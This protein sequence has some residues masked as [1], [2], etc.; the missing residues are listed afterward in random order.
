MCVYF[1]TNHSEY[2]PDVICVLYT[3]HFSQLTAYFSYKYAFF[4]VLSV[5][6]QIAV[7]SQS[8]VSIKRTDISAVHTN[9][10]NNHCCNENC[11]DVLLTLVWAGLIKALSD[12]TTHTH[13]SLSLPLIILRHYT[14]TAV[15]SVYSWH[16]L[17]CCVYAVSTHTCPLSPP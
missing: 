1:P 11:N 4:Y 10:K 8:D 7:F 12:T 6:M 9:A 2:P 15:E 17:S 3:D 14:I 13:K 5:F 16:A